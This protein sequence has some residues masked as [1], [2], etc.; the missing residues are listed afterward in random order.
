M[1]KL[2]KFNVNKTR[3]TAH[4]WK[5]YSPQNNAVKNQSVKSKSVIPVT[6]LHIQEKLRSISR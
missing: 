1:I 3:K 4:I 2:I 5:T 6:K